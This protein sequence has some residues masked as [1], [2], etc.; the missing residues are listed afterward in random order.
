MSK[1]VVDLSTTFLVSFFQQSSTEFDKFFVKLC[2]NLFYAVKKYYRKMRSEN[3]V[4][5][6]SAS[7]SN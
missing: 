1:N 4:E 5:K 3:A 2:R 7:L 6:S